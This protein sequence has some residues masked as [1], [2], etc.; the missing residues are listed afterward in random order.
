MLQ[1]KQYPTGK[2]TFQ[3]R[4]GNQ[5]YCYLYAN[6]PGINSNQPVAKFLLTMDKDLIE[7]I[8]RQIAQSYNA[9]ISIDA[10]FYDD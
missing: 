9:Q 4:Y 8:S 10:D 7:H 2:T 1:P 3:L 6:T 5:E